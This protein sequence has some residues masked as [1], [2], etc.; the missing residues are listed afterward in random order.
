MF[1]LYSILPKIEKQSNENLLLKFM[2]CI[3]ILIKSYK[4]QIMLDV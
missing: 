4:C 1:I 3:D 2:W